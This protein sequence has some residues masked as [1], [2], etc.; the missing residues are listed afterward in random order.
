MD[1]ILSE[2]AASTVSERGIRREWIEATLN[3]P[4]LKLPHESDASVCYAFK[5]IDDFNNRVL[6]VIYNADANPVVIVTVYF[7]RTMRGKL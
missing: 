1:Y 6:R 4:D 3:D 2:H 7:D 5:R